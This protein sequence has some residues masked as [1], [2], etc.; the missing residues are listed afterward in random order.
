MS[1]VTQQIINNCM[2][3]FIYRTKHTNGKY[4]IGRH[5]TN[6]INDGYIG[7]GRWPRSIKDKTKVKREILEYADNEEQL[8]QLEQKYLSEHF[9]KT[10][11]MN[12][13]SDPI[14][15]NNENNPMKKSEIS[16]KISGDNH[17]TRKNP[18][19]VLRGKSHWMNT[20]PEAKQIF[21]QSNPALDGRNS[22]L[23]TKRGRNIFQTNNPSIWRSKQGIHHWQNGNSPNAGGKLNKKLVKEGKHNFLG[24][25]LNNR[26]IAEGTHNFVG[27]SSNLKRLA[28]G[29][30]PSQQ[31][32]TCEHCGKAVSV[33][34]YARWHGDNCK[35]KE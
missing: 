16:E 9:D 6:N 3:H 5:S 26:R 34:M 8:I 30:H 11:C 27:S 25:D 7:S 1:Y 32:K 19:K 29:T 2:K 23:A 14:G 10:N 28:E 13:T 12:M 35:L 15:F 17:W 31:K 33:G 22:K 20:N 21:L 18:N 24:P 4:Y